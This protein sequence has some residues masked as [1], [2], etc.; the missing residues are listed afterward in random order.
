[1]PPVSKE[2]IQTLRAET[3]A[4]LLE[5]RKA[6]VDAGGDETK[7]RALL[8]ERGKL[9]AAKKGGRAAREG[10]IGVYVHNG[11]RVA[12]MVRLRCETDFVARNPV[13]Q[14]LARDV[15]MQVVA[16]HP[17]VLR[18][19]ETPAGEEAREAALL[20]QP[21]VKDASGKTTVGDLLAEKVLELGENIDVAEFARFAT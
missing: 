3:G 5:C 8:R 9:V 1:M 15:A 19:E 13:F 11:G 6:L 2:A 20:A 4:P 17:T 16:M 18:P 14:A 7:A 10:T 21:F 12:S